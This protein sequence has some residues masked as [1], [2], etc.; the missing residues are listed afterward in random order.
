MRTDGWNVRKA[1]CDT[2]PRNTSG[3]SERL[4]RMQTRIVASLIAAAMLVCAAP[5]MSHHSNSAYQVEKVITMVGVVK[6]WKWSNPHTW[7]YLTVDDGKGGK[8]EW[9]C[10]GRAPGV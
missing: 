1:S 7:L 10:E 3:K 9:A 5:A 8:T 4:I 6:E 2:L